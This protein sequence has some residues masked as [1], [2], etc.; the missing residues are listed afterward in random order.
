MF[1]DKT[2]EQ[3]HHKSLVVEYHSFLHKVYVITYKINVLI[4]FLDLSSNIYI[5]DYGLTYIPCN[6]YIFNW[7]YELLVVGFTY[8]ISI[9]L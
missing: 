3:L 7:C 8:F 5:V 1:S 2:I 9:K 4:L 6:I